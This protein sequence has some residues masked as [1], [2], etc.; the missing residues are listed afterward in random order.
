MLSHPFRKKRGMD[1]A[2]SFLAVMEYR[3]YRGSFDSLRSL[4]MTILV[5]RFL[6]TKCMK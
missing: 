6:T 1:G 3:S 5:A 2:R 4:R